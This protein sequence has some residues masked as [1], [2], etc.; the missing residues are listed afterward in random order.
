VIRHLLHTIPYRELPPQTLALPPVDRRKYA[1][2]P[3]G[4]QNFV[5]EYYR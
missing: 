4:D 2:P 3:I 1:R 5:P